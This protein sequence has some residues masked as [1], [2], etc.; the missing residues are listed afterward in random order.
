M[1]MMATDKFY[2]I[3]NNVVENVIV[4]DDTYAQR[5]N[6]IK[7]PVNTSYGMA[8]TNW[9]YIDGQFLPPPRD[10]LLEWSMIRQRRNALLVE[11]DLYVMPD[12]WATYSIEKQQ[13][14]SHYRQELRDIPQ[15]FVDPREVV[16][17][18]KPE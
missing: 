5:H 7:F 11:S 13:E 12:K 3:R 4:C 15:K 8:D 1:R 17:P 18:T 10:V 14:W 9:T 2:V 16:F 6:L